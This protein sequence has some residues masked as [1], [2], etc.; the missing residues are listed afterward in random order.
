MEVSMA[1][2]LIAQI[3]VRDREGYQQYLDGFNEVFKNY[4]GMIMAAD[5]NP[6][7]LEGKW[8]CSRTVLIRFPDADEA[9]RWYQSPQYQ[10]LAEV[11]RAASDSNIVLVRGM[12]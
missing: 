3:D 6:T 8:P 5:V 7:V 12:K 9:M 1:C 10:K 4:K 2:Y 11:R